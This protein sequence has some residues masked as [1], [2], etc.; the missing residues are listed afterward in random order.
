MIRKNEI[1]FAVGT[2]CFLLLFCF[3]FLFIFF[4]F[5]YW[6]V[7]WTTTDRHNMVSLPK[8]YIMLLLYY[9]NTAQTSII[10]LYPIQSHSASNA[11]CTHSLTSLPTKVYDIVVSSVRVYHNIMHI[12]VK[13][14]IIV[15]VIHHKKKKKVYIVY[16]QTN[17]CTWLT[18]VNV[19]FFSLDVWPL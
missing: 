14:Y 17:T 12:Y 3:L 15:I 1:F 6:G 2:Y 5:Y 4:F 19:V 8:T 10:Q 16:R 13:L 18:R 9:T 7:V 11:Y